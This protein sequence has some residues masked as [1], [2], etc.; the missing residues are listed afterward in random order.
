MFAIAKVAE[1]MFEGLADYPIDVG[2]ERQSGC[3]V[4]DGEDVGGNASRG[5]GCPMAECRLA[6]WANKWPSPSHAGCLRATE[7]DVRS[8]SIF[9]EVQVAA[10]DSTP[11]LS[12]VHL[13]CD[14]LTQTGRHIALFSSVQ[15]SPFSKS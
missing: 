11:D 1:Q 12:V 5:G 10:P 14:P 3:K 6:L 9:P 2:M 15:C 13:V 8:I 7:E 4:D